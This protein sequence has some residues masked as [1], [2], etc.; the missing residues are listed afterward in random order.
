MKTSRIVA[1][2]GC[3][4]GLAFG[5]DNSSIVNSTTKEIVL[6][7]IG[8]VRR[9]LS[10]LAEDKARL[11]V[12]SLVIAE[13]GAANI[14]A[15]KQGLVSVSSTNS[16]EVVPIDTRCAYEWAEL[17]RQFLKT[18]PD[19]LTPIEVAR[20]TASA[21]KFDYGILA[22]ARVHRCQVLYASDATLRSR[23]QALNISC[24]AVEDLPPPLPEQSDLFAEN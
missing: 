1:F 6:D 13:M 22:A 3:V 5:I 18:L 2:D 15:T 20:Q 12:P 4:L 24:V 7:G 21:R 8:R 10:T 16:V 11:I 17:S 9:L 14:E 19:G 23:A